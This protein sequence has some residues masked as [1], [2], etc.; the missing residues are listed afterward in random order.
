M[1]SKAWHRDRIDELKFIREKKINLN[2]NIA[3]LSIASALVIYATGKG[4]Q[5]S[6]VTQIILYLVFVSIAMSIIFRDL[7]VK[8]EDKLIE[9]NYDA[10]LGKK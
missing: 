3:L 4:T 5:V 9:K 10:L 2:V 6:L 7:K 1:P 8:T